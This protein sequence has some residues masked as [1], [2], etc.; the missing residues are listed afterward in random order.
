MKLLPIAPG[1]INI[2]LI[3]KGSSTYAIDSLKR[4]R[5]NFVPTY[6]EITGNGTSPLIAHHSA[7][8]SL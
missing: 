4:S 8:A 1:S 2:T 6:A 7:D 3:P 5:A